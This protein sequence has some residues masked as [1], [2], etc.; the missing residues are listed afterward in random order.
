MDPIQL[1]QIQTYLRM[2]PPLLDLKLGLRSPQ[3]QIALRPTDPKIRFCCRRKLTTEKQMYKSLRISSKHML[4]EVLHKLS[5]LPS[6]L[7][8]QLFSTPLNLLN[9]PNFQWQNHRG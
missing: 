6:Q 4:E 5:H 1:L 2:P 7:Q 9:L 3:F 8:L